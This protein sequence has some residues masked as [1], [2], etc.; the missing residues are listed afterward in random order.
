MGG[1]P[2]PREPIELVGGDGADL[3]DGKARAIGIKTEKNYT[4][5]F[6]RGA[7]EVLKIAKMLKIKT[8]ILK[9][10]SPSCGS[11]YIKTGNKKIKGKGVTAAV[12]LKAEIKV[13]SM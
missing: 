13:H 8:A 1:L 4:E 2:A 3:L 12:L 11:T 6:L 9:D 7:K 10:G 5:N